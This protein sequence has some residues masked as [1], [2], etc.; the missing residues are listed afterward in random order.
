VL[1]LSVDINHTHVAQV[2]LK[3]VGLKRGALAAE[4]RALTKSNEDDEAEDEEEETPRPEVEEFT[5]DNDIY[6]QHR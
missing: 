1:P 6:S 2:R 4:R 5:D 3:S